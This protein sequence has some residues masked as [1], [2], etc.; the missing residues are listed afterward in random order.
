MYWPIFQPFKYVRYEC[1]HI[2]SVKNNLN[3]RSWEQVHWHVLT[4]DRV[5]HVQNQL[6]HMDVSMHALLSTFQNIHMNNVLCLRSHLS[7]GWEETMSRWLVSPGGEAV[8]ERPQE[9][10]PGV[11]C[12]LWKRK[13]ELRWMGVYLKMCIISLSRYFGC[14]I[15]L[16]SVC[17]KVAV[18]LVDTQGAFDS[19]STIK[20]CATVFA[21]STMTSS[22]QVCWSTLVVLRTLN[23]RIIIFRDLTILFF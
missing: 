19:Q 9:S 16:I 12:S 6:G 21:L 13:T 1:S 8:R 18:L 4:C 10:R 20:D 17:L 2:L 14:V 22:V 11:R 5:L 3:S 7:H 23:N 15:R